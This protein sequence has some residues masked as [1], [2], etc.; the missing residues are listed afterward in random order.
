MTLRLSQPESQAG[1][2]QDYRSVLSHRLFFI[3]ISFALL[4]VIC[5]TASVASAKPPFPTISLPGKSQ[6]V[7]AVQ[8]L[9]GKLPEVAA[10]YGSTPQEFASMLVQD[11]T[12]WIDAKGRLFFIEDF[13]EPV[14]EGG[15]PTLTEELF[16]YDQTFILHSRPGAKRVL[17]LDFDG[18]M[19]TGTA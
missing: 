4:V 13:P 8:V 14:V 15:A 1:Q 12:A 3:F 18:H 7:H 2:K 6:G 11:N 17:F 16:P 9:A 5:L 10:W 19:T